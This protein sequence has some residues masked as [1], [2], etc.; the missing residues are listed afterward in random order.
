V[1][2]LERIKNGE[3]EREVTVALADISERIKPKGET[4]HLISDVVILLRSELDSVS[5]REREKKERR[6]MNQ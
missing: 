3:R 6:I 5:R 4:K 1:D 2:F